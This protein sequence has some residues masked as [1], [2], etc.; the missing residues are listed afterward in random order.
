MAL[1]HARRSPEEIATLLG[2]RGIFVWHGNYYALPL[3]EAL[4]LEPHGMVRIGL[5]H[6]NTADEVD[7][8][9]GALGDL[10]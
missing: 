7:R 9:L 1:T 5:L 10:T 4:D 3:T 6:Y 8:C 2:E